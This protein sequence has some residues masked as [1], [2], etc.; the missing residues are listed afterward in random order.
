MLNQFERI[1]HKL[2]NEIRLLR[3]ARERDLTQLYLAEGEHLC[4]ELLQAGVQPTYI[5]VRSDAQKQVVDVA[6]RLV[7]KGA[8]PFYCSVTDMQA[9]ASTTSPQS[10]LAVVPYHKTLPIGK[11]VIALDSVADP[12][13]V[14]TI[15]RCASW[16]GFSD[17]LLGAC[18]ADIYNPKTMRST[19]GAAFRVN[20]TR[21]VSLATKLP[22]LGAT[23][24]VAAT[25][26][27][28]QSTDILRK[29]SDI[30]LV[31]GNEAHGISDEVLA[32]CTHK[33]GIPGVGATESLNAAVATAILAF[34]S[35]ITR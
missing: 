35:R 8:T 24:I 1:P 20:V 3:H 15:V 4:Q 10:I 33:V 2:R 26:H 22:T 18:C 23:M 21:N 30:V 12:G 31:I 9:M 16:F 13:N 11:R 5:I 28:S 14:G 34:E 19:V 32:V 29:A 17:V 6:E 27:G 7:R 25:T